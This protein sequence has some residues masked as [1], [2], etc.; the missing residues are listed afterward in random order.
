[1]QDVFG[2]DFVVR[3]PRFEVVNY[4]YGSESFQIRLYYRG[5]LR[6]GGD[7]RAIRLDIS[8]SEYLGLPVVWREII[9]PYGD[10]DALSGV[11]IPS[12]V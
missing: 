5:S 11:K 7:P 1:L 2:L 10:Y 8:R 6:W 12:Y 3:P 9:H 4:E